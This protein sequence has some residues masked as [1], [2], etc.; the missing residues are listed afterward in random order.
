[1]KDLKNGKRPEDNTE[2]TN[3][4]QRLNQMNYKN[5]PLLQRAQAKLNMKAKDKHIDVVFHFCI[6]AMAGVLALYLNPEVSY[7]WKKSSLVVAKLQ[8]HSPSYA[9]ELQQWIHQ[10]LNFGKLPE[11][12]YKGWRSTILEDKDIVLEIQ[13]KL[14]EHTKD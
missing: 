11:H 1:L 9:R 12:S 3:I 2:E 4:D 14:V 8:E 7:T 5:F 10:F 13:L 6:T